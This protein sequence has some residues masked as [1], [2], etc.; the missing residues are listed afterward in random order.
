ME[1]KKFQD[2]AVG[3]N[4]PESIREFIMDN[5]CLKTK[6]NCF[7]YGFNFATIAA[8]WANYQGL[9]PE[10]LKIDENTHLFDKEQFENNEYIDM[11]F[12]IIVYANKIENT[13]TEEEKD[14]TYKIL[15]NLNE[16]WSI[17]Q[18]YTKDGFTNIIELFRDKISAEINQ[19]LLVIFG[20]LLNVKKKGK[21]SV[22]E[23]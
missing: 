5:R 18:D 22:N 16:C 7:I 1:E 3:F 4:V 17:G 20:D 19:E 14:D 13:S 6:E 8:A 23:E 9:P 10:K 12:Q 11:T 15:Y 21:T 2:N